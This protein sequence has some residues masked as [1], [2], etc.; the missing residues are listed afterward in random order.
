MPSAFYIAKRIVLALALAAAGVAMVATGALAYRVLAE[1]AVVSVST[2]SV[3]VQLMARSD[4]GGSSRP[5]VGASY[6]V[7]RGHRETDD[8]YVINTADHPA[9]VRVRVYQGAAGSGGAVAG[10]QDGF[11]VDWA[12]G[13]GWV[14]G[15]DGWRYYTSP[16]KPARSGSN[17][18]TPPVLTGITVAP[19]DA[20]AAYEGRTLVLTVEVQ[21][22]QSEHNGTYYYQ[23]TG[24]DH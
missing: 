8:V 20:G 6:E 22:V 4:A 18:A 3:D 24:W 10:A 9:W 5:L 21:A 23:A 16:L 13:N 17:Y 14:D 12:D 2:G 7:E 15:G 19:G 11:A 1:V